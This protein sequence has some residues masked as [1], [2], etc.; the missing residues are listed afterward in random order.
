MKY[1]LRVFSESVISKTQ[2]KT[3]S[4]LQDAYDV[5]NG[6]PEV[7]FIQFDETDVVRHSLVSKIIVAYD[8]AYSRSSS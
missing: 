5:L 8:K 7:A 3:L 1:I 2:A 4:G 6:L